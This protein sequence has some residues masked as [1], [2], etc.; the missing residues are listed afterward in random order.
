LKPLDTVRLVL[1]PLVATHAAEVY[2]ELLDPALYRF[3]PTS[4]PASVE[5]LEARYAR[6]ESRCSPDG[7]EVWLNWVAR[8]VEDRAP[9]GTFEVT[10]RAEN[11]ALLAYTVFARFQRQGL[12]REACARIVDSLVRDWGVKLVTAFLHTGNAASIRLL[13]RLGLRRVAFIPRADVIRGESIDEF[14]YELHTA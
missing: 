13:E 4:P 8:R 14:R 1:E 9:V 3:I 11:E 5:A 10:L 6:L 2:P 7:R 12:A